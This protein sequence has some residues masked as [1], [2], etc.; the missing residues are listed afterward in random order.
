MSSQLLTGLLLGHNLRYE[1]LLVLKRLP[2]I[3][4]KSGFRH[5]AED[6]NFLVHV[7]LTDD[8]SGALFQIAR[9]PR[10]VQIM[11]RHKA[12]LDI[13][14]CAHFEGAAHQY[15]HLTGADLGKQFLFRASVFAS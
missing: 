1:L 8:S 14:T 11:E 9:T 13:H 4:V 7:S 5:I 2:E 10:C 6:M 12:V 3:G 15:A